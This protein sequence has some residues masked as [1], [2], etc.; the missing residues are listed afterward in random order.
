LL[1]GNCW[2]EESIKAQVVAART[3]AYNRNTSI[4]TTDACQVYKGGFAKAWAAWETRDQLIISGGTVIDAF[5]S[6]YNNNGAG[7]ADI[8]TVWPS[9]GA[10]SYLTSVNDNSITSNPR[11]C[12]QNIRRE[13]WRSNSYSLDS[14]KAML[15]WAS[16]DSKWGKDQ[17]YNYIE[18]APGC[19]KH[20]G[21]GNSCV[22]RSKITSKIGNLTS[23]YLTRDASGRVKKVNFIG[24]NGQGSVSG[25]FFRMMF[26]S[27][28]GSS[29][30]LKSIT[31]NMVIAQ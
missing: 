12:G 1:G 26:N 25:I 7:N 31:F 17:D 22:V 24:S 8:D 13:N 11:F 2:P 3:Y 16:D 5:Y 14:F 10:R 15:I 19:S 18:Y 21:Y 29:D 27:W 28:A 30:A 4:C 9:S 23:I 20:G 6:A